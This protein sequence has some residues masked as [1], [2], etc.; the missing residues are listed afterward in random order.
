[1]K[2][3]AVRNWNS[4]CIDAPIR[5]R[6]VSRSGANRPL[7]L[8]QELAQHSWHERSNENTLRF[9]VQGARFATSYFII[10]NMNVSMPSMM[11]RGPYSRSN[12][13]RR[14]G[15]RPFFATLSISLCHSLRT[16]TFLA[17][18]MSCR[19]CPDTHFS[20]SSPS[21]SDLSLSRH[22]VRSSVFRPCLTPRHSSGTIHTK[23]NCENIFLPRRGF[24]FSGFFPES[25]CAREKKNFY[26]EIKKTKLLFVSE[27]NNDRFGKATVRCYATDDG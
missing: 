1:M 9:T 17:V 25:M 4:R 3:I 23:N 10:T 11:C 20:S 27:E 8:N 12:V 7:E 5:G 22:L 14:L 2:T 18:S 26:D 21:A 6:C 16:I 24:D 13:R 19:T 15:F